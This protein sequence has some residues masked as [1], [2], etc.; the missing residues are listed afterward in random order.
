MRIIKHPNTMAIG[1]IKNAGD[2]LNLGCFSGD[3]SQSQMWIQG[4][5]AILAAI[6][7]FV[8]TPIYGVWGVVVVLCGTYAVRLSL[9]YIV[10]QKMEYL[11][12]DHRKWMAAVSIAILAITSDRLLGWALVDVHDFVLGSFVAIVTL[13]VFVRYSVIPVPQALLDKLTLGKHS[14]VS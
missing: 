3:S 12:Y 10:S 6:G 7:Y 8:V 11:P 14:H 13:V 1:V 5:C 2:Y 9:L 4:G